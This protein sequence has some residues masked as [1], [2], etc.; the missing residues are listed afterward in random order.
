MNM[1]FR[2]LAAF[3]ALSVAFTGCSDRNNSD[4][5][6]TVSPLLSGSVDST[7]ECAINDLSAGDST[8]PLSAESS[9][10][11]SENGAAVAGTG[12]TVSGNVVTITS[13]G[14]YSVTGKCSDGKIIIEAGDDDDVTLLLNGVELTC[15]SNSAIECRNAGKL[16]ISLADGTEN[17]IADKSE[18][19]LD[20][21]ADEPDAAIY[22]RCDLIING[23][24]TL[25]VT[26][27]YKDGIKCKD[28]LKL[29]DSTINVTSADDGIKGRDYIIIGGAKITVDSAGDGLKTTNSDDATLGYINITSGTINI[30]SAKDAIQA[31]T[32]FVIDDGNVEIYT[33]SGSASVEHTGSA[34]FRNPFEMDNSDNSVSMKGIKAGTLVRINGGTITIDSEDDSIHSNGNAAVY[35]GTLKLSTGDDGIH[36]DENLTVSGG[37]ITIPVSYE[38]LEGKSIDINGGV[39]D[40][41]SSDDGLNAAGG[42]SGEFFGFTGDNSE[43]YISISGGSITVNAQGDGIDSNGSVAMSGGTVVVF[44]PT[45]N[46]NGALDYDASF[47][48]SG[49]TLI[50]LGSKGMAQA[51]STLSQPCI[52]IYADV[53]AG[54]AIEVRNSDGETVLSVETPKACQSLIFSSADFTVGETYTVYA[55]ET[56]LSTV[57]VSDGVSGNGVTGAGSF[58]NFGDFGGGFG[59]FGDKPGRGGDNA[60]PAGE[61]PERP[62]DNAA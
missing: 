49:G 57:T 35:G 27:N 6:N 42:D 43:Y 12:I 19:T 22:S 34:D 58:G 28:G 16:T 47:A 62:A 48:L 18:Y 53:S 50:A 11:F 56:E 7:V 15:S 21:G 31:E 14:V 38:G 54:A 51:P 52:S 26:G 36:A 41:N 1:N 37:S 40:I 3:C 29:C 17:S 24:G 9:V 25:N 60:P 23:S 20:D 5:S 10:E 45:D 8:V 2:T 59:G 30:T 44:G 55:D 32:E 4:S 33:G 13:A 46:G 39:I 61:R